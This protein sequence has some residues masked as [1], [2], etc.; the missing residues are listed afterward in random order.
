MTI[1]WP[2]ASESEL[3]VY[4]V[5][6]GDELARHGLCHDKGKVMNRHHYRDLAQTVSHLEAA[7]SEQIGDTHGKQLCALLQATSPKIYKD[8]LRGVKQLLARSGPLNNAT[9]DRLCQRPRF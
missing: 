6:T 3:I 5:H 1:H 9:L 4:D 7:I 2:L 8:Q